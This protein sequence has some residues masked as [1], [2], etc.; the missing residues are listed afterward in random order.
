[1]A[2]AA[3]AEKHSFASNFLRR[4]SET[5]GISM[6]QFKRLHRFAFTYLG[7]P[8]RLKQQASQKQKLVRLTKATEAMYKPATPRTR[9][10]QRQEHS[11][12]KQDHSQDP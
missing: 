3:R 11:E 7:T 10:L 8:E 6:L 4:W 5:G 12:A 9:K 2:K 1:M